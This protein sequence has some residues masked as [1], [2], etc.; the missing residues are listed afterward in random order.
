MCKKKGSTHACRL[1]IRNM[2]ACFLLFWV[3]FSL[4]G[5]L[6]THVPAIIVFNLIG[7]LIG[8]LWCNAEGYLKKVD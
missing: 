5:Y 6:G 3:E 2:Q 1:A 4:W 7:I 8:W